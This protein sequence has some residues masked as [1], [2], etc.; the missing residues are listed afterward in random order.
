ME[1]V[2]R[3]GFLAASLGVCTLLRAAEGEITLKEP[4]LITSAGQSA[5][6][7]MAE[8]LCK[9]AGVKATVLPM[10][11]VSDLKEIKTLV[12][13][14]GFSSKGLGA[15]GVSRE[16]E[17]ERVKEIIRAAE[18]NGLPILMMHIGGTA[19]RGGQ[20][21]DFNKAAAEAADCMIVVKKGDED[22]LFTAIA[23]ER[24]VPLYLV[25][26]MSAAVAP[27]QQLFPTTEKKK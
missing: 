2:V 11:G 23:S 24:N 9:K 19:R 6:V 8:L 10:A 17:M 4:V 3:I 21:D 26:K 18:K 15:A 20:S 22:G 13:V 25:E 16:E 5:D 12:I 1:K 27:L 7:S 14:A